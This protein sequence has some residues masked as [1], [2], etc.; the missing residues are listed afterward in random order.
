MTPFFSKVLGILQLEIAEK[1][2][3]LMSTVGCITNLRALE[4]VRD[5]CLRS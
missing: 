4:A 5:G 1:A 2:V 3:I